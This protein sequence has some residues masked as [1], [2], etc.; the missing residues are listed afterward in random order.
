MYHSFAAQ[1][2]SNRSAY[3]LSTGGA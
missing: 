1:V 2:D 3:N